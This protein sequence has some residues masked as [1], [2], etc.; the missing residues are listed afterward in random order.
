[1]NVIKPNLSKATIYKRSFYEQKSAPGIVVVAKEYDKLKGPHL[2]M[3]TTYDGGF[4]G[5]VG[6]SVEKPHPQDLL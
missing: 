4:T 6:D 3:K 2:E 1:M 5:R